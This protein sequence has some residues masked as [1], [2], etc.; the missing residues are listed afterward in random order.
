VKINLIGTR[1]PY[2]GMMKVQ[3]ILPTVEKSDDR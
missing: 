1:K 2:P 3:Q